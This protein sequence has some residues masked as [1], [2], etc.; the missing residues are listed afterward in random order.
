MF[1]WN[2]LTYHIILSKSKTYTY[3][4]SL[5]KIKTKVY[6]YIYIYFNILNFYFLKPNTASLIL[7][8]N[9]IVS[10]IYE[11]D[12]FSSWEVI[13]FNMYQTLN[14]YISLN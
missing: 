5:W 12:N 9:D 14:M 2:R 10:H 13:I 6:I 1:I 4:I 8:H 3:D 11:L 7:I